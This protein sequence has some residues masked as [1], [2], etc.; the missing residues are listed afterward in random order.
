MDDGLLHPGQAVHRPFYQVGPGLGENL[1]S[2]VIRDM[3]LFYELPLEVKL[4]LTGGGKT[5]LYFLEPHAGQDFE[6]GNLLG[7]V[8]GGRQG[9]VAVPE[10][11]GTPDGRLGQDFVRPGTVRKLHLG[12]GL[13]F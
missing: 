8:H 13:V 1:D 10:I 9:L 6:I 2:H 4:N 3:A 11:H 5:H 12:I 7:N